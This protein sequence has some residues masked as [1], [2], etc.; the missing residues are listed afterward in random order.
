MLDLIN[1]LLQLGLPA[2]V[3]DGASLWPLT[4]ATGLVAMAILRRQSGRD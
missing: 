2:Q 3:E 4:L 1:D